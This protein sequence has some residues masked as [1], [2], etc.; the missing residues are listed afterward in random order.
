M[1]NIIQSI[2]G[3]KYA[4]KSNKL[5]AWLNQLEE[6]DDIAAL[7]FSANQLTQTLNRTDEIG[8]AHV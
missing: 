4:I 2:F 7:Q 6:L 8:R 5:T 1:K 3:V